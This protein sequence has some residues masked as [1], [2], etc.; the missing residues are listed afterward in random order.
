MDKIKRLWRL[1]WSPTT[2]FS[3]GGLLLTGMVLGVLFWGGFNWA[4]ALSNTEQF[5]ISCHEMRDNVYEE[6][7]QFVHYSNR[8]GVRAICSDCHVPKNWFGKVW[9]KIKATNE[10]YHKIMGTIDTREKFEAHRLELA[11]RVWARMEANDSRACRNC[12]HEEYMAQ[13]AQQRRAWT[14]H[15][16]ALESGE[17]C[18]DCHKGIAHKAVHTELEEEAAE[19]LDFTF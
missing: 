13:D 12:H 17:T 18:I 15:Q 10:L 1:F 9:R 4:M 2:R 19:D 7:K 5:C 8:S 14:Q 6:S 16:D 11:E 3:V